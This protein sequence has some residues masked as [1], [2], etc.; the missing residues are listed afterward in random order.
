MNSATDI[1]P[2]GLGSSSGE[3]AHNI[4]DHH[5]RCGASGSVEG[6][7]ERYYYGRRPNGIYVTRFMNIDAGKTRDYIRGVGYQGGAYR[8][9]WGRNVDESTIEWNGEDDVL[10]G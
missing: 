9:G 10:W 4:M 6:S 1:W 2:D 8:R 3:L 5:F 7:E